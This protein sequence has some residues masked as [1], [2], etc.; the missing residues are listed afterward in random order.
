MKVPSVQPVDASRG[1]FPDVV[2]GMTVAVVT[3]V[4]GVSGVAAVA[5][6]S[7]VAVVGGAVV[8]VVVL[9]VVWVCACWEEKTAA[10][11]AAV[12]ARAAAVFLASRQNLRGGGWLILFPGVICRVRAGLVLYCLFRLAKPAIQTYGGGAE[13]LNLSADTELIT[14]RSTTFLL[15]G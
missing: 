15:L 11:T 14:P 4:S 7:V 1:M 12:R 5:G 13:R 9:G 3:V 2:V 6:V 8:V 10:R